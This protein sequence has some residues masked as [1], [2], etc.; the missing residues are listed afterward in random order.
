MRKKLKTKK[1]HNLPPKK[2]YEKNHVTSP[3][4]FLQS[5]QNCIGPTI[6]ISPDI[7]CLL[8][9]GFET[10]QIEVSQTC[11]LFFSYFHL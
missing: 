3:Q 7:Q 6:C 8:Y 1:R 2:Y 4:L 11:L 10:K 5:L 9:A